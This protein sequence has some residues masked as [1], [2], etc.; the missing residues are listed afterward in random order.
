MQ[1]KRGGM[2][3]RAEHFALKAGLSQG[4]A[5]LCNVNVLQ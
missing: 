2:Q 3:S 1:C 5:T 4:A